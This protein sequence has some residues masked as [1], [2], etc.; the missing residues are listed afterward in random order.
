[1]KFVK[2]L[3]TSLILCLNLQALDMQIYN[4][5]AEILKIHKD[6]AGNLTINNKTQIWVENPANKDEKI[7]FVTAGYYQK[8][9]IIVKNSIND[10]FSTINFKLVKKQY[11][12]EKISVAQEKATPPKEVLER[13]KQERDEANQIYK[14]KS[15][16]LIIKEKF[17]FP[18]DS[19]IT[20]AFGT[21][22]IFNDAVK[23]YH[24]GTDFRAKIGTE[25]LATNDGIVRIAKDRFYSGVSVV[26]EHGAGIFT[27]YYHL[28]KLNVKQGDFV[29]KGQILG[30]SGNSGRVSGPHLHFGV[31]VNANS[32]DPLDFIEK[33]NKLFE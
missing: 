10:K 24:S 5:Q 23:S 11:K 13:I 18:M 3:L 29:K 28:S 20:S 16:N 1:M 8:D 7:A 2:F 21:A 19:Q 14:E 4:G 27:Q 22:R 26:L 12:K 33:F 31:M 9:D 32:I 30:L 17:I 25:I 6:L 15:P